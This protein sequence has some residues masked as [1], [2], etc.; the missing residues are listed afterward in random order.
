MRSLYL[1]GRTCKRQLICISLRF[2][3]HHSSFSSVPSG[4]PVIVGMSINI[5]S[6]DSISEVNMVR[7][8]LLFFIFWS[9]LKFVLLIPDLLVSADVAVSFA[10]SKRASC[11]TQELL[12]YSK[13]LHI[14]R[15]E[16]SQ[17]VHQQM[18][19][20]QL[21]S[22][23]RSRPVVTTDLNNALRQGIPLQRATHPPLNQNWLHFFFGLFC[24]GQLLIDNITLQDDTCCFI[25]AVTWEHSGT[26]LRSEKG[27]MADIWL[28]SRSHTVTVK[29]AVN[30][31]C[32]NLTKKTH[33]A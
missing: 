32:Q 2:S 6:I 29:P 5:A 33:R 11:E 14:S 20:S 27:N 13:F 28:M 31:C 9:Q 10:A 16:R 19:D 25:L 12:I 22:R 18:H 17:P 30:K 23:P 21:D 3:S 1:R 15:R 24:F 7:Y 8:T 26:W 4:P